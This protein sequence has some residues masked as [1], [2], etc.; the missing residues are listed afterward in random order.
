MRILFYLL[1]LLT[2]EASFG[3]NRTSLMTKGD[4]SSVFKNYVKNGS[5]DK[6]ITKDLT[7]TTNPGAGKIFFTNHVA[8]GASGKSL[9]L[10]CQATVATN[11]CIHDLFF[12][13]EEIDEGLE[14][15]VCEVSIKIND[16]TGLNVFGP[17]VEYNLNGSPTTITPISNTYTAWKELS[18][19]VPCGTIGDTRTIR[20]RASATFSGSASTI[21]MP[22]DEVYFG[23]KR[24]GYTVTSY[25]SGSGTYT[26]PK[27]VVRLEVQM[28]GGGGG[29]GGSGTANGTAA[30]NG[31]DTSFNGTT[32]GGGFAGVRLTAGN[33]GSNSG[34]IPS[35]NVLNILGGAGDGGGVNPSTAN[36]TQMTGGSGGT[37]CYGGSGTSGAGGGGTAGRVG[38][39][40]GGGGGGNDNIGGSYSG[41]GGGAGACRIF[42][43]YNL[44]ETYSYAVGSGGTAGGA[45]TSGRAGGAGGNG[46]IVIKEYYQ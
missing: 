33:G 24:S 7:Y 32:A 3:A 11:I 8:T 42:E 46:S 28:V 4:G 12:T 16:I 21:T 13:L 38:T 37:S 30:G 9:E 27:N 18:F 5:F 2:C 17:N 23:Q 22:I 43:Q 20:V 1:V 31:G 35:V 45:G 44:S 6:S 10:A 25:S 15:G 14:D 29:G 26:V 39:G 41:G 36:G 19:D 34:T 40:A